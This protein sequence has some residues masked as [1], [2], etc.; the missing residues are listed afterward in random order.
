MTK[1]ADDLEFPVRAYSVVLKDHFTV[2]DDGSV[3]VD[4]SP[5][6]YEWEDILVLLRGN[7]LH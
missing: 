6:V 4:S 7:P 5:E 1:I 2:Y 3:R